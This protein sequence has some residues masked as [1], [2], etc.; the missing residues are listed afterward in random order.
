[1][2]VCD[3]PYRVDCK[4]IPLPPPPEEENENGLENENGEQMGSG[5]N[6]QQPAVGNNEQLTGQTESNPSNQDLTP[7]ASV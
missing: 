1:M 3:Y 4:G 2:G 6:P 5:M 7:Q